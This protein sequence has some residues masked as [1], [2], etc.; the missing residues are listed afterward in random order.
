MARMRATQEREEKEKKDA[1]K[2][3]AAFEKRDG[4]GEAGVVKQGVGLGM[5]TKMKKR[6]STLAKVQTR[7]RTSDYEKGHDWMCACCGLSNHPSDKGCRVC[8]RDGSYSISRSRP[9]HGVDSAKSIRSVQGNYIFASLEGN[10]QNEN[11][12]NE[13]DDGRWT[14]LHNACAAANPGLCETLLNA[15]AV[16]EAKTSLGFRPLHLAA[17]SQSVDCVDAILH[18]HAS[19]VQCKTF[20]S[21][22]SPLH[23]AARAGNPRVV[24]MLIEAGCKERIGGKRGELCGKPA[25]VNVADSGGR[26]PL[27]YAA[28]GGNIDAAVVILNSGG[29]LEAQD[30]DG[31][32]A[33]QLAEF[34]GHLNVVEYLYRK[35]NPALAMSGAV[36]LPSQPWHSEV[37]FEVKSDI[38]HQKRDLQEARRA[39]AEMADMVRLGKEGKSFLESGFHREMT[40][41]L[42]EEEEKEKRGSMQ[43]ADR[44][45]QVYGSSSS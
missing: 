21:L 20:S 16:V 19:V 11:G 45:M 43:V 41:D 27:H 1:E 38:A 32:K 24:E 36:Q 14:P 35:E 29:D 12:V 37:Y 3:R 8:G 34:F 39:A 31:W 40:R 13:M 42:T 5:M 28:A 22:V 15:G 6:A 7:K 10:K 23:L 44:H 18:H 33:K 2:Q 9:A 26:T 17:S 30:I 4:G 25:V